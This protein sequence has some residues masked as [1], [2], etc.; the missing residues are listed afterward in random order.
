MT[1]ILGSL[2]LDWGDEHACQR[3]ARAL[4]QVPCVGT[5]LIFLEGPLGAGKTTWVRHLLQAL[6]VSGRIK[7]PTFA[8]METYPVS[9][10]LITH[11]DFYRFD[12]PHDWEDAGMRE[13][14]QQSGL[15][16]VE[17]PSKAEGL[18]TPDL[19]VRIEVSA[20]P[21]DSPTTDHDAPRH[22]LV[23]AHTACGLQLLRAFEA[24]DRP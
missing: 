12:R 14:L 5:A 1:E 19:H 20:P 17:W 23:Q 13:V 3:C 4:A 24:A 7:S 2:S 11:L 10:G 18:P 6:G 15:K 8:L 22:V 16:L 21:S 9:A